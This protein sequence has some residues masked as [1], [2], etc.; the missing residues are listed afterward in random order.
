LV[1][2]QSGCRICNYFIPSCDVCYNMTICYSCFSNTSLTINQTRCINC[3]GY[4]PNCKV[5]YN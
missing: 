4:I 5:C 3:V 1:P 2:D